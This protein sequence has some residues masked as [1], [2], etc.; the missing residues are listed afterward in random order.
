MR[1]GA[2][3]RAGRYVEARV[4]DVKPKRADAYAAALR[5]SCASSALAPELRALRTTI[6]RLNRFLVLD[7]YDAY[8]DRDAREAALLR[9]AAAADIPAAVDV[10]AAE[11][12]AATSVYTEARALLDA[13]GLKGLG[14]WTA[15][16]AVAEERP[17]IELRTYQLRLGYDTVPKF[18]D[19]YGAGLPEKLAADQTGASELVTLLVSEAGDAPL[20]T[21]VEVWRH[22]SLEGAQESRV[23]SRGAAKWRAS[24]AEIA[25]L[26]V[27]FRTEFWRPLAFRYDGPSAAED[28]DWDPGSVDRVGPS[29][30]RPQ[31]GGAGRDEGLDA[32]P[33][34]RQ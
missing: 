13:N 26:A 10:A 24:I 23:A 18:L 12:C 19:L 8:A 7:A 28:F 16:P 11:V 14:A 1:R 17:A 29:A 5:A 6:G 30:G 25:Q 27:Q 22:R 33:F 4:A 32:P 15:P 2:A 34:M 21:V 31:A 3:R 20:N 9:G